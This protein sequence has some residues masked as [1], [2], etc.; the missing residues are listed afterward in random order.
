[1]DKLNEA[2]SQA[3]E[4]LGDVSLYEAENK[5]RLTEVLAIQA[6]AKSELEEVE[7]EWMDLQ[8]QIEEKENAAKQ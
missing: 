7:I 3:E 1:M 4:E 2:L 5:K 6:A 8:E